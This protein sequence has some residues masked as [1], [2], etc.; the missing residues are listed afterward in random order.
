MLLHRAT[1]Y[2]LEPTEEQER[3]FAQWAGACRFVY[4]LA[5]HLHGLLQI[6]K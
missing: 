1:N 6:A 3:A 4:N 2:R 5:K